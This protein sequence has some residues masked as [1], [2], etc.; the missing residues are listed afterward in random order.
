MSI[1]NIVAA[2]RNAI[3]FA[4]E[5]EARAKEAE[6]VRGEE[7]IRLQ[8]LTL[9]V[10]TLEQ[11]L[12]ELKDENYRVAA[13]MDE[14]VETAV[15]DAIQSYDF[16]DEV[17]DSV[18]DYDFSDVVNEVLEYHDFSREEESI[19]ETLSDGGMMDDAVSTWFDNSNFESGLIEKIK[20]EV[21]N[22]FDLHC[23]ALLKSLL[24][25]ATINLT[26]DDAATS[27]PLR[28]SFGSPVELQRNDEATA[29][30]EAFEDDEDDKATASA[31]ADPLM[32]LL[33]KITE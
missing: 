12:N 1:K 19:L 31:N 7:I 11:E 4:Y 30:V 15:D 20:D 13:S 16:S 5:A 23:T 18:N 26:L 21:D 6:L 3:R 28:T 25:R 9:Q 24:G 2:T 8:E 17:R 32:T 29:T 10:E 33:D 27:N 14:R 22:N